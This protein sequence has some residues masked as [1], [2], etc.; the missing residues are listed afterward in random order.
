MQTLTHI[1]PKSRRTKV[2]QVSKNPNDYELLNLEQ[3]HKKMGM[4]KNLFRRL[5]IE[6]GC[7]PIMMGRLQMFRLSALEKLI[8]D[9]DIL[10]N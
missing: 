5:S 10:K 1:P 3:A 9:L 8:D 2:E 4:G 6:K 7:F